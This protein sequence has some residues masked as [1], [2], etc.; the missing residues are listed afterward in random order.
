MSLPGNF[1]DIFWWFL[2]AS[3][4][5]ACL[6]GVFALIGDLFRAQELNHSKAKEL[7][8]AGTGSAEE[9]ER[10]KNRVLV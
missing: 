3:V 6:F 4:F 1:W 7:L 9:L 5:F 8:D 10:I 2:T